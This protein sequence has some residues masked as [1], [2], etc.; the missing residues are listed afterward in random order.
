[1]KMSLANASGFAAVLRNGL[2]VAVVLPNLPA[3][4]LIGG[5]AGG[6]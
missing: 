1:M 5:E 2:R 3:V 6:P 4:L